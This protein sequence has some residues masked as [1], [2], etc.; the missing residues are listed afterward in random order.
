MIPV[1]CIVQQ[2]QISPQGEAALKAEIDATARRVFD[3]AAQIDWIVV[4]TGY[5][6]SAGQ[7]SQATVPPY[8]VL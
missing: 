3:S 4:P 5:G 7:P 6:F 1:M 2:D 8:S